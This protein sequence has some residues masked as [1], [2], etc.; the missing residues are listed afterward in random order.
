MARL[1]AAAAREESVV[2]ARKEAQLQLDRA[3]LERGRAERQ[4]DALAVKVE[5]LTRQCA[6]LQVGFWYLGKRL[7]SFTS[8]TVDFCRGCNIINSR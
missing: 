4:R 6:S 1:A 8:W 5:T 7:C 3:L 2:R